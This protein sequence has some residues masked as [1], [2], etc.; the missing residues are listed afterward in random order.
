MTIAG[1][2]MVGRPDPGGVF[3]G[4][5]LKNGWKKSGCP[6]TYKLT[7]DRMVPPKVR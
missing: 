2:N 7:P 1:I 5:R 6:W 3:V 4:K